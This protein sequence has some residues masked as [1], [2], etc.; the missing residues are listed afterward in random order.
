[1]A[2]YDAAERQD[3]RAALELLD[4]DTVWDMRGLGMPDLARVYA[5]RD[6]VL[7]FWG[8]WLAAWEKIEFKTIEPEDYGDHIIVRIEQRNRGQRKRRR[9]GLPYWQTFTVRA[10]KITA[11]T[12][13][14]TRPDA[15][16]A[17]GLRE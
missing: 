5:G 3:G 14:Q 12:V 1:M 10:G 6:D 17:V 2:G 15:L 13:A 16:E 11:S 7:G 8:H 9:G 4:E